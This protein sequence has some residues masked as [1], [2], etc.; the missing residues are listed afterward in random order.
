MKNFVVLL[1]VLF[2][3]GSTINVFSQKK[4]A[5]KADFE[6]T[7]KVKDVNADELNNRA[8]YWLKSF[9]NNVDNLIVEKEAK[10]NGIELKLSSKLENEPVK[11]DYSISFSFKD[12]EYSYKIISLTKSQEHDAAIKDFLKVISQRIERM[13]VSN[14]PK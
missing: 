9:Y 1:A 6:K 12:S 7:I 10:V 13:M 8:T 14:V 2:V 3:V 11:V 5:V 4:T